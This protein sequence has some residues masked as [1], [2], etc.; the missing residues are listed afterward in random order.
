VLALKRSLNR[1]D[2]ATFRKFQQSHCHDPVAV[3]VVS[4]HRLVTA[5][6]TSAPQKARPRPELESHASEKG[7]SSPSKAKT[8]DKFDKR[9]E[10]FSPVKEGKPDQ[11]LYAFS[12]KESP[13]STLGCGR[14]REVPPLFRP[15]LASGLP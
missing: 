12:G 11:A 14:Q 7:A 4:L 15:S 2:P 10:E 13:A 6:K 1:F 3:R 5:E 8:N 9:Q